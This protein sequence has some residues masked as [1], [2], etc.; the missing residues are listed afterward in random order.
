MASKIE[1][2]LLVQSA[3]WNSSFF[4]PGTYMNVKVL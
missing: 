2:E 1:S 4:L 3:S